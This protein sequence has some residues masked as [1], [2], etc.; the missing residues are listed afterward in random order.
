MANFWD[1]LAD[2][3]SD[4]S[5]GD[6]KGLID[7]AQDDFKNDDDGKSNDDWGNSP[8]HDGP[9]GH[10]VADSSDYGASMNYSR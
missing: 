5:I 3:T 6:T 2:K 4:T 1:T 9:S 10:N 7:K 8:S